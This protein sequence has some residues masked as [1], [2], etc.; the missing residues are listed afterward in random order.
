MTT[1][2]FHRTLDLPRAG[3]R[4]LIVAQDDHAKIRLNF[5]SKESILLLWKLERVPVVC[6]A[7]K[8]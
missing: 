1:R 4:G 8:D 7:E 5:R 2:T 3:F 6:A